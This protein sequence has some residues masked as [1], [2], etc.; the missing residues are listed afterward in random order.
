MGRWSDYIERK[1][2]KW[3]GR[4]VSYRGRQYKVVDVDYN[5]CIVIDKPS[6]LT[7]TTAV[8]ECD[9]DGDDQC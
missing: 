7:G 1:K 6:R 4:S 9:L 5:G 8:S 2:Q 3:V